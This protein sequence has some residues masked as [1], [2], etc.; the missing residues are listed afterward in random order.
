MELSQI[1]FFHEFPEECGHEFRMVYWK[2]A[3]QQ[4]QLLLVRVG[5]KKPPKTSMPDLATATGD[6]QHT[7]KTNFRDVYVTISQL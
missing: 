3:W 1:F 4:T 2:Q 6:V 5:G 7:S